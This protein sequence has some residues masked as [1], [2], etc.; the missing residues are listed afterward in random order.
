M[1]FWERFFK[2]YDPNLWYER[3]YNDGSQGKEPFRVFFK[4]GNNEVI[5]DAYKR[6][7]K[8][9]LEASGKEESLINRLVDFLEEL[10]D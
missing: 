6:G 10:D 3:G 9:G 2:S 1:G 5:K 7:Y 8:N 4:G